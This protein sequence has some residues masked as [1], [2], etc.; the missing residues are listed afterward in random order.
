LVVH[1]DSA[2]AQ[3]ARVIQNFFEHNSLKRLP[4]PPYS[5]DISPSDFYLFEKVKN[6]L[7]G[8]EIPDEPALLEA[9]TEIL[10]GFSGNELQVVFHNWIEPDHGV[11]DADGGFRSW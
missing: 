5:P 6:A 2:S 11:I 10:G 9:V 3:D 7:I 8:Q 1:I 4:Q